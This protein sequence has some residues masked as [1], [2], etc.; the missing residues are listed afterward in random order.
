MTEEDIKSQVAVLAE[1]V[2]RVEEGL[3]EMKEETSKKFDTV[4]KIL[5]G[6]SKDGGLVTD[7]S[8]H[9]KSIG[10]I[11]WWL[12]GLSLAVLTLIGTVIKVAG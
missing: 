1:I 11:W 5:Q 7:V 3:K 12:G 9:G 2:P 4:I 8:N 10:R 6:N